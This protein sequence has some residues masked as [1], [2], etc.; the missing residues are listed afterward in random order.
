MT[1][2]RRLDLLG[3]MLCVNELMFL[4]LGKHFFFAYVMKMSSEED[5]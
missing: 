2:Q 4:K 3:N 5:N 1:R